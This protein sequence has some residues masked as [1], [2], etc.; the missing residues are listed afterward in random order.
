MLQITTYNSTQHIRWS[1][2]F[3]SYTEIHVCASLN[4]QDIPQAATPTDTVKSLGL[5]KILIKRWKISVWGTSVRNGEGLIVVMWDLGRIISDGMDT[6]YPMYSQITR[7]WHMI[8]ILY[9]GDMY[10]NGCHVA[11]HV[12]ATKKCEG[13][14]YYIC[15]YS[16]FSSGKKKTVM[17]W[18]TEYANMAHDWFSLKQSDV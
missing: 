18:Y 16:I 14:S 10:C 3:C 7:I 4:K 9:T 11:W 6:R 1:T 15:V 8:Q 2:L 13:C 17:L 12:G 5:N